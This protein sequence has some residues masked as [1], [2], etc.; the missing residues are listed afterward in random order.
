[1]EEWDA[2]NKTKCPQYAKNVNNCLFVES[3]FLSAARHFR[4]NNGLSVYSTRLLSQASVIHMRLHGIIK[5][6]VSGSCPQN[7]D[8]LGVTCISIWYSDNTYFYK[9]RDHT[10]ASTGLTRNEKV[11]TPLWICLT[12]QLS[13]VSQP[14]IPEDVNKTRRLKASHYLKT[15]NWESKLTCYGLRRWLSHWMLVVRACRPK[16][17][18]AAPT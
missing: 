16:F 1:M 6:Q 9:F 4:I 13:T 3:S 10:M 18:S 15:R 2:F 11:S 17:K 14:D 5:I 7:F 12:P 8:S